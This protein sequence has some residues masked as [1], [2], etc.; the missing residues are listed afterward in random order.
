MEPIFGVTR[1]FAVSNSKIMQI[2]FPL[3]SASGT[4]VHGAQ[5]CTLIRFV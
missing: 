1:H 2:Q 5:G 4:T 3:K